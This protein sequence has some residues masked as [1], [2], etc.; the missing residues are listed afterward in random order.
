MPEPREAGF[1]AARKRL[2]ETLANW[3]VVPPALAVTAV[4]F[5]PEVTRGGEPSTIAVMPS[6]SER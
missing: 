2:R 1:A 6:R 5:E 4:R 3:G